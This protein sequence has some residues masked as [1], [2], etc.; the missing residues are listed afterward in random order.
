MDGHSVLPL[1]EERQHSGTVAYTAARPGYMRDREVYGVRTRDQQ[2]AARGLPKNIP[3]PYQ[4]SFTTEDHTG[5]LV[6]P[7]HFFIGHLT[8]LR[9]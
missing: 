4:D 7:A 6:R 1:W 2:S 3:M 8:H 9:V 5:H